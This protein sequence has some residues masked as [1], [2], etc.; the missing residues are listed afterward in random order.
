MIQLPRFFVLKP[1][2]RLLSM[3]S[4]RFFLLPEFRQRVIDRDMPWI[5]QGLR[6]RNQRKIF[7]IMLQ[8]NLSI[9]DSELVLVRLLILEASSRV[10]V[11]SLSLAGFEVVWYAL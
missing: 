8:D 9:S 11:L 3:S 5:L 6:V 4:L 7:L 2:S 1:I 10:L